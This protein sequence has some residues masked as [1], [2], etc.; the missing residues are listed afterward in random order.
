MTCDR[1][2]TSSATVL[3]K[4]AAMEQD[5]DRR[6]V[7]G[8]FKPVKM[9]RVKLFSSGKAFLKT[10]K[11]LGFVF[12]WELIKTKCFTPQKNHLWERNIKT[13]FQLYAVL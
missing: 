3:W 2:K 8:I 5:T 1:V 13:F 12:L 6:F 10:W 4:V 11:I 7:S 9:A